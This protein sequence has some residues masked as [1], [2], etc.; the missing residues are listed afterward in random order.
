M[1]A[2][3]ILR[4]ASLEMAPMI[5]EERDDRVLIETRFLQRFSDFAD[6]FVHLRDAG[7]VIRQLARP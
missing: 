3:L 1:W 2:P 7:K 6:R 5:A 4:I